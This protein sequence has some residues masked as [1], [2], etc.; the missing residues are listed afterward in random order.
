M[1][2]NEDLH[3]RKLNLTLKLSYLGVLCRQYQLEK[4]VQYNCRLYIRY[5]ANR[6]ST[7]NEWPPSSGIYAIFLI[8]FTILIFLI[9]TY[10]CIK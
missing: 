5:K 2:E 10:I 1:Q 7:P 3:D 4:A 8:I 9:E 6:N